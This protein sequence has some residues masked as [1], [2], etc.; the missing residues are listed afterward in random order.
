M[1]FVQHSIYILLKIELC[2]INL[3][4]LTIYYVNKI[5]FM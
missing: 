5:N 2:E 4:F 3:N 1:N